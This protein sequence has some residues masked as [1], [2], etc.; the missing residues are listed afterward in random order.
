MAAVLLDRHDAATTAREKFEGNA[1]RASEEVER[2]RFLEIDVG[3]EDVEEVL[4]GE[5][6][7]GTRLEGAGHF[8]MAA[9]VF[10]RYDTHSVGSWE[11]KSILFL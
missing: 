3:A 11:V 8:E 7:G 4:L 5:I 6:C 9:F 1:A 10:T 2:R